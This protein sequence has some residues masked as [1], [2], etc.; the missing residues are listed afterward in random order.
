VAILIKMILKNA[1]T[2]ECTTKSKEGAVKQ[3]R[4]SLTAT[5]PLNP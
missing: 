2:P 5:P 4:L 3:E 1:G